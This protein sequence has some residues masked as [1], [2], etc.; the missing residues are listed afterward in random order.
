MDRP[1]RRRRRLNITGYRIEVSDGRLGLE[2]P[3]VVNTEK[4]CN[5]ICIHKPDWNVETTRHYRVSAINSAGTGPASNVAIGI[6]APA[7]VPTVSRGL[8][9]TKDAVRRIDLKWSTPSDNG[10][11]EISGYRIEV[12][13]NGST[14]SNLV[15]NTETI[16]TIHSHTGLRGE[17]H[18][19][20]PSLC[21]QLRRYGARIECCY[22]NIGTRH[23]TS[24]A[25]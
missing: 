5:H 8:V 3:V 13:E 23:R 17:N 22:R 6:T 1:V 20:L 4:H 10:G 7:T 16:A 2:R 12:S 18:A 11:A 19:S 14:W 25:N 9:A 21:H 15:T 24:H